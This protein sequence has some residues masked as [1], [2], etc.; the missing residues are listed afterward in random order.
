[1]LKVV[2]IML[3]GIGVGYLLRRW[4]MRGLDATILVLIWLLLF[5]L[6]V[7]V[8]ENPRIIQGIANLGVEALALGVAGI[9]GSAV[10][11]WALW[12]WSK[13]AKNDPP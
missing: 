9:A 11:S 5:L 7:E 8:G 6:G 12:R 1:M 13:K 4:R 10:L 2:V 3:C